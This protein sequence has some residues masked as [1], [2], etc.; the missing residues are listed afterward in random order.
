MAISYKVGVWTWICYQKKEKLKVFSIQWYQKLILPKHFKQSHLFPF[1]EIAS[2]TLNFVL[3]TSTCIG[4]NTTCW[5][6][7]WNIG[8]IDNILCYMFELNLYFSIQFQCNWGIQS[9]GTLSTNSRPRTIQL[10]PAPASSPCD[11]HSRD[12]QLSYGG[13]TI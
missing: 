7:Y 2:H 12:T 10:S 5:D 4:I 6:I 9:K 8:V 11:I 3:V 13:S 1:W